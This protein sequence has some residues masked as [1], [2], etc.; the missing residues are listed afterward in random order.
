MATEPETMNVE[1]AEQVETDVSKRRDGF[2]NVVHVRHEY[3]NRSEARLH[4]DQRVHCTKNR[5]GVYKLERV[6]EPD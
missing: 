3:D 6:I 2:P 1:Q 4:I 5:A